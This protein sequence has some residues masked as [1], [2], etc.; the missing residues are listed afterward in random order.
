MAEGMARLLVVGHSLL[1][2]T[3]RAHIR[4]TA[5]GRTLQSSRT[6]RL[7]FQEVMAG[8]RD[9]PS[10]DLV[11]VGM[12]GRTSARLTDGQ[13]QAKKRLRWEI[14]NDQIFPEEIHKNEQY[15]FDEATL[16]H[17]ADFLSRFTNPCCLCA[18]L[19]G[20][21]LEQ[22]GID[23]TVLDVDMR[24]SD[25]KGFRE[26]NICRPSHIG[27][28]FDI[29]VCDPPFFNVSL[30][31]LFHAIRMLAQFNYRQAVFVSYLSRRRFN[32][33]GTFSPFNIRPTGFFPQY[34]SLQKREKNLIE[35]FGNLSAEL[36]ADLS[37]R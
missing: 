30:S 7:M 26:Y 20:R 18:P 22:R 34:V 3:T 1:S 36:H 16:H 21:E 31:K 8:G 32:I 13:V 12:V 33:M 28:E 24:F 29:I 27:K 14:M 10:P 4:G 35:F 25:L 5:Q 2:L 17:M 15:F 6:A 9:S 19:L 23:V 37:H 11:A